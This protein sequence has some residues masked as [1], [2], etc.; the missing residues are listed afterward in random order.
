MKKRLFCPLKWTAVYDH[1]N[2]DLTWKKEANL[3][4]TKVDRNKQVREK[5]NECGEEACVSTLVDRYE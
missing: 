5:E 1:G 2:T 3:L 4:S